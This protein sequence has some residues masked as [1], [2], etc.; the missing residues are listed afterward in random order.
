MFHE[1]DCALTPRDVHS[2]SRPL[3]CRMP[4]TFQILVFA[5]QTLVMFKSS[6]AFISY[7]LSNPSNGIRR[8][9]NQGFMFQSSVCCPNGFLCH[10]GSIGKQ[11]SPVRPNALEKGGES[12]CS[13]SRSKMQLSDSGKSAAYMVPT[14]EVEVELKVKN[15]L[16]IG[17]AGYT[18][19]VEIARSDFN[20]VDRDFLTTT[21]TAN[22]KV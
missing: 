10:V 14:K 9:A 3:P 8:L 1:T 18:P 5:F 19:S 22:C 4:T 17:T 11:L 7:S 2:E 20:H 6:K 16:F 15:S 21:R 13:S 12:L